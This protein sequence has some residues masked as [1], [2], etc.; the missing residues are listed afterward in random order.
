MIEKWRESLDS[1][2]NFGAL[3]TDLSKAFDCLPHDLLIA[4]LHAY[5]LDMASLKLLHSYLTKRRQRVK[6]NNTYSSWSEILFGVPQGSI[7]G[8]LLFN[9]FLCDLFLF[10]PDIGIANYADDNTLHAT[11]KHLETVLKDLEQGSGTLLEWFTDNLIKANPES[12]TSL[13]AQMKKDI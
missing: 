11:I 4:K 9:I 13:L 6:I 2:G 5:G 12:I 10:V 3:L 7:L 8:P 1:G